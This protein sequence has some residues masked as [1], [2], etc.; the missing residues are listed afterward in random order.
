MDNIPLAEARNLFFQQDG[1]PSHNIRAVSDL[2]NMNFGSNWIGCNGPVR[3]PPRSPDLSPLD[4]FFWGHI[5]NLL[6][7]R[8]NNNMQELTQNFIDCLNSTSRIHIYNA[9]H[10]VAKRCNTCIA[11]HGQQFE[12]L[13]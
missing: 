13:L 8:T 7:R 2:L 12:H 10:S 5:K 6:Y 9:V 11:N 4:F 1:A 3:W